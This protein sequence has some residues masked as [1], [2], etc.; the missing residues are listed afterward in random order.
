MRALTASAA[1]A[2][3]L[4]VTPALAEQ[5][6]VLGT[7]QNWAAYAA[8]T[9]EQKVCYALSTPKSSSPRKKRDKIY[10]LV[11]DWPSRNAKGESEIVPG[12]KYK[13]GSV[14]TLQVGSHKFS[15]FTRNDGDEGSAW[16][17]DA[18]DEAP[19]V[20]ALRS[21]MT[22]VVAGTSSRGST[23]RDTYGLAGFGDAL[24]KAHSACGM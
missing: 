17:T 21:N 19:I 5:P 12:F 23:I 14:V 24:D 4:A 13:D 6:Q 15:L 7:F 16:V 9:G 22:A 20:A 3:I 1:I 10:F 18:A 8:G 11:S 2:A